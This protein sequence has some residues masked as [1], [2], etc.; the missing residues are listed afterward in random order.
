L[1]PGLDGALLRHG[2]RPGLRLRGG[3]RRRQRRGRGPWLKGRWGRLARRR[4]RGGLG[5]QLPEDV[6]PRWHCIVVQASACSASK[7]RLKPAPQLLISCRH[8]GGRWPRA[9]GCRLGR[10]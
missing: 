1:G 8:R 9:S 4:G 7:C 5:R 3:T 6:F 10:S 2:A